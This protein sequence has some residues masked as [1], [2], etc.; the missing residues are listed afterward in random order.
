M[1][2]GLQPSQQWTDGDR[3]MASTILRFWVQFAECGD[4]NGCPDQP[5]A[6]IPNNESR[7]VQWP[8]FHPA[9]PI[10]LRLDVPTE[11]YVLR[12]FVANGV[13]HMLAYRIPLSHPRPHP[14]RLL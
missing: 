12:S 13:A 4:P 9:N 7:R 5:T 14:P 2:Q 10:T 1:F 6:A 11:Q 3:A 8:T